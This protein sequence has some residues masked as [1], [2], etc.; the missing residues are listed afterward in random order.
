MKYLESRL[1]K[2]AQEAGRCEQ[3]NKTDPGYTNLPEADRADMEFF[4][5]QIQTLLPV[6]GMDFLRSAPKP[7]AGAEAALFTPASPDEFPS[8]SPIF[9]GDLKK[10]DITARGQEIDGEFVVMKG[11]MARLQWEG[12]PSGYNRLFQE[13]IQAGVLAPTLDGK[14]NVFTRDY[15]FSS[16]S[17]AAA[18]VSGR[19]ANGRVHWTVE[20]SGK[21][22]AEWQEEQIKKASAP[23]EVMFV[24]E[25]NP[26][27]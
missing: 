25:P 12:G 11:S 18:V 3:L 9:N 26:Q 13:L 27:A 21:T 8:I 4:L 5:E 22:Y 7:T 17:A 10:H 19:N 14:H 6:L 24:I 15:A 23:A 16:P 2:I 1:I 20:G